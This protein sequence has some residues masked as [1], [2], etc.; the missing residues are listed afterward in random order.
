MGNVMP[1][2]ERDNKGRFAK[3]SDNGGSG[4][5]DLMNNEFMQARI[6]GTMMSVLGTRAGV[7][8]RL[9]QSFGGDRDIFEAL[10]YPKQLTFDRFMARYERQEIARAIIDAPVNAC[11]R[12]APTVSES[13]TDETAFEKAWEDLVEKRRLWHYFK[14]A[15]RL[16]SIGRYGVILLGF[17]DRTDFAMPVRNASDLLY[18]MPYSEKSATIYTT[19]T[20]TKSERYGQPELYKITMAVGE[21][22]TLQKT[23]HWSRVIH[24]AED[25]LESDVYGSSRLQNIYNRLED[26]ERIAGSSGE[27]FWRG[28]FP[29]MVFKLQPDATATSQTPSQVDTQVEE[30]IHNFRRTLKLAGYDVEQLEPQVTDPSK[31]VLTQVQ[32]IAS[33]ARIPV[34]VLLGSERGELASTQDEKNW[35]DTV[36]ARRRDH[37]E[38]NILRPTIDRLAKT[39][40]LP[41]APDGYTIKWPELSLPTVEE[42]AK[43]ADTISAAI[44]KYVETPGSSDMFPLRFFAEH[45]LKF[46]Q[47]QIEQLEMMIEEQRQAAD[48]EAEIEGKDA[49]IIND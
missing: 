48:L 40:M 29:G 25:R 5:I 2:L 22:T 41:E 6:L 10:G 27:M 28:A 42:E 36:D 3:K 13:E 21:T 45:V 19:D 38:N 1:G 35:A 37:C 39:G 24:I 16:A 31:H 8:A 23:V 34:R 14:R 43:V 9:G 32:L 46:N 20:D 47:D 44:K 15:D 33:Q 12:K 49:E 4:P 11:W 26:L 7:A 18:A 30:Y 17:N